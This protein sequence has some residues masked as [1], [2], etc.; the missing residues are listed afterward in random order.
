[1]K[2]KIKL[3]ESI[4]L[5]VMSFFCIALSVA[6]VLFTHDPIYLTLNWNLFLAFIPWAVTSLLMINPALIKRKVIL[7]IMLIAWL[8][9]FPNAPYILTD[10][11]HLR[12][13][14]NVP[15][16]FDFIMMFSFAWT[17][18]LFGFISL[19]E[20]EVI[21]ERYLNRWMVNI[22]V[23]LLLFLG[24]YGIYLGRFMHYNSWDILQD[25]TELAKGIAEQAL[26]PATQKRMYA[27]TLLL[28]ILLNFMFWSVK[29]ISSRNYTRERIT[30]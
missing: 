3:T 15:L 23:V 24:S 1:M 22:L 21:L 2:S 18:L 30:D 19:M 9:F 26:N 25:P 28:G 11:F 5:A 29:L 16:W 27:M 14:S 6:R 13:H 10:L 8:A 20:M 7:A 12:D 17:G 4:F